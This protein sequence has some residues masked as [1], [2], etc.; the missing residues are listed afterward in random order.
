MLSADLAKRAIRTGLIGGIVVVYL[1]LVGMIEKFD[2][3]FLV[4]GTVTLGKTM[5][6]IPAFVAG[7]VA[8]RPKVARGLV[9]TI[10]PVPA[11]AMGAISGLVTGGLAIAWV[12]FTH[13]FPPDAVRR[14]FVSASPKLEHIMR[15][16][17]SLPAAAAILCVGGALLGAAGAGLRVLTPR[18][19]R[20]LA[21]GLWSVLLMATLQQFVPVMLLQL[22]ISTGWLYSV[23]F[24]GLTY[25]GAI[26]VFGVTVA[27]A[28]FSSWRGD[29]I[30]ERFSGLHARGRRAIGGTGLLLVALVLL[31]LPHL[32]G[33]VLSQIL[34]TVGIY[35]LMGLGLNI[36][37]GYA[38][39]LDLGYVAF[40]A[41]GAY[42]TALFTGANLVTSLGVTA[43]PAFVLHLNFY[44]AVPIVVLV[45]AFTGL[46]IGAPVLRLR[47]DYLAIVTLGFGEIA[48]VLVTS[49]W[50]SRFDGGAQGLQ[51]VTDAKI[52]TVSFRNPE[53]FYYLVLAFCVLA[54][55]VSWRL[56]NSRVGR[57]WAAMREDEQVAETMG[58][59]TTKYKLLAFAMGASVGC[60]SG[61]LFAVQLGSLAPTTFIILVSITALSVIILGGMGSIPGVIV[62]A[63][64][65]IGVPALLTEFEEFRLLLYGA[66]LVAVMILRPQGL[67]PNVRRT[68]ELLKEELAQD[69]WLKQAGGPTVEAAAAISGAGP[70]E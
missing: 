9:E 57:A 24:S 50:L 18:L 34:G 42:F 68:R 55:F 33:S 12:G 23:T 22:G 54:V 13:A 67:I 63:L 6:A 3:R 28:G 61:A 2:P 36:V 1:G 26:L 5:L 48:R 30:R 53:P 10:A 20:P 70:G 64:V 41:V 45:A 43:K 16:G 40:F 59:S 44:T 21:V 51:N 35:L 66:V 8:V 4:G 19:R 39:L 14:I 37:V 52:G 27:V 25:V 11:L 62:G 38:G 7:Y 65:L 69:E 29:Q 46:M 31:S 32:V 56:A 47:G 58:I 17:R 60:L 49:D 15:F